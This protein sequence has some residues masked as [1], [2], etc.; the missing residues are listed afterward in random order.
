MKVTTSGS[1]YSWGR[2]VS[3]DAL[4]EESERRQK[5]EQEREAET[6]AVKEQQV[7]RQRRLIQILSLV[8]EQVTVINV[9]SS[10]GAWRD[11]VAQRTHMRGEISR[12]NSSRLLHASSSSQVDSAAPPSLHVS[13]RSSHRSEA[14]QGN[15][16]HRSTGTLHRGGARSHASASCMEGGRGGGGG[17]ARSFGHVSASQATSVSISLVRL[18]EVAA[19]KVPRCPHLYSPPLY[20][21]WCF[22][23]MC[24][25]PKPVCC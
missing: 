25:Q 2:H 12:R 16:S 20:W 21:P 10:F 14:S 18:R 22:Q 9:P 23:V 5:A 13:L 7:N 1:K 24:I 15:M 11:H 17:S 19:Q 6:A 3:Q 4:R 8:V